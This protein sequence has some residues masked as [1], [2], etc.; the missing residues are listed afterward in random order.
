MTMQQEGCA[1]LNPESG[2][3]VPADPGGE[4]AA[5]HGGQAECA[6]EGGNGVRNQHRPAGDVHQRLGLERRTNAPA[7]QV[8]SSTL[9]SF[10]R[11][12]LP[13]DR[14]PPGMSDWAAE[15]Q[16]GTSCMTPCHVWRGMSREAFLTRST[17]HTLCQSAW[18]FQV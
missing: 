9:E 13:F 18:P 3:V 2:G 11:F 6:A 1:A 8:G 12:A 4:S 17:L 14:Q 16:N 15:R 10:P 5:A 7:S